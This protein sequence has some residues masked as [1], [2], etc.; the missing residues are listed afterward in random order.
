MTEHNSLWS[1]SGD[2]SVELLSIPVPL[3]AV[4]AVSLQ[5]VET[6]KG[7]VLPSDRIADNETKLLGELTNKRQVLRELTNQ[8]PVFTLGWT[9]L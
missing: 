2:V 4:E 7:D 6:F 5:V 9:A 3:D 1:I 8:K